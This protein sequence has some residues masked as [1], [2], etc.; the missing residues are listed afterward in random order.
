[1]TNARRVGLL[2]GLALAF[3]WS[4]VTPAL[5]DQDGTYI[6][7]VIEGQGKVEKTVGQ[8][9]TVFGSLSCES[10]TD[11]GADCRG[12][13]GYGFPEGTIYVVASPAAGF[14]FAAWTIIDDIEHPDAVYRPQCANPYA[15]TCELHIP[16]GSTQGEYYYGLRARFTRRTAGPEPTPT[17]VSS[18]GPLAGPADAD[19][20]GVS[21]SLDCDDAD[22]TIRP[23][24]ID[25]AGDG[26]DQDCSGTD[27]S[28][29]RIQSPVTYG[30]SYNRRWSRANRLTVKDLPAGATIELACT[31]KGCP[32]KTKRV[33]PKA[34][35]LSLLG[36]LK[37]AK[38]RVGAT[39]TLRITAPGMTGKAS[40]S[41]CA[42][43]RSPG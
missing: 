6:G 3:G 10:V 25:V 29:P 1:M 28:P 30:W 16:K 21:R 41:R 40:R 24:A 35:T 20:D 27:A 22:A 42:R 12:H 13:Q 32:F 8:G 7:T 39:L 33:K 38:L 43:A 31:G 26:V 2:A 14:D 19:A 17:P 23:G 37:A 11:A 34:R 36:Q 18:P 15:N 9:P 5:A 4:A